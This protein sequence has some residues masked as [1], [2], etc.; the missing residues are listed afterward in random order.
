MEA[1]K[2]W[3][4]P[5]FDKKFFLCILGLTTPRVFVC[6]VL[7]WAPRSVIL[8]SNTGLILL[9][10]PTWRLAQ[11]CP[12]RTT[13][14]PHSLGSKGCWSRAS[15]TSLPLRVGLVPARCWREVLMPYRLSHLGRQT[16]RMTQFKNFFTKRTRLM[17]LTINHFPIFIYWLDLPS[18][19][20]AKKK[21]EKCPKLKVV[22]IMEGSTG[23]SK[24]DPKKEYHFWQTNGLLA[25]HGAPTL[26][27]LNPAACLHKFL[28]LYANTRHGN[29]HNSHLYYLWWQP[30]CVS[31]VAM[32]NWSL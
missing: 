1:W 3:G 32:L 16:T 14:S 4:N 7:I 26:Q 22:H 18:R 24:N 23:N 8:Y 28:K 10:Y 30:Y 11:K 6:F 2:S 19:I 27:T 9:A 17:F 13:L 12:E 5:R 20:I 21:F 15:T 25:A 31:R 29:C